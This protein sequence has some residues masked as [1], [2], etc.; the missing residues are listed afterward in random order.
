MIEFGFAP[1]V[2]IDYVLIGAGIADDVLSFDVVERV[3][4]LSLKVVGVIEVA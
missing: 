3:S 4:L 1:E 2:S